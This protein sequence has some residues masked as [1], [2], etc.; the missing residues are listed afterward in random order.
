MATSSKQCHYNTLGVER[1]A[2]PDSIRAAYKRM[3]KQVHPDRMTN[4]PEAEKARAAEEFKQAAAAYEV[5]SDENKRALYDA[6][7]F[8][9]GTEDEAAAQEMWEAMFMGQGAQRPQAQG[10]V[11]GNLFVDFERGT[12]F[13]RRVRNKDDVMSESRDGLP[14]GG[15]ATLSVGA[16][17]SSYAASTSLPQGPWEVRLVEVDEEAGMVQVMCGVDETAAS[18]EWA[19]LCAEHKGMLRCTRAFMLPSEGV[20]ASTLEVAIGAADK[21]HGASTR[22]TVTAAPKHAAPTEAPTTRVAATEAAAGGESPTTTNGSMAASES[23]TPATFTIGAGEAG[24][25][26]STDAKQRRRQRNARRAAAKR[27]GTQPP[28]P[29]KKGALSPSAPEVAEERKENAVQRMN[30][31]AG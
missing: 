5:L 13:Q 15:A 4:K 21:D 18:A 22:L 1:D 6:R 12:F 3:A 11:G 24:A 25:A 30:S 7:G 26:A 10:V 28:P 23:P 8:A 17:G 31:L 29:S 20:D 9:A 14:E 19:A 27:A 16:E 2:S